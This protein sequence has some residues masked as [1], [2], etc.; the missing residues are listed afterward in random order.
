MIRSPTFY[1]AYMAGKKYLK[2]DT[3]TGRPTQQASVD[4]SAG[5]GNAGDIVALDSSG[6]IDI[7]MM[8][9]GIGSSAATI[10]ASEALSAG[11]LVNVYDNSGTRTIRKANAT[12]ATKPAH[13]FVLLSVSSSANG[14]VY[15]DGQN[16]AIPIGTFVAADVGKM[17]FL[18]TIAGGVTITPPVS[19]GNIVQPLGAIISVGAAV[20]FDFQAN[21]YIV[22]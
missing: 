21:D 14:T 8:P 18:N 4:A 16:T 13:G 7:T 20:A 1:E 2:L 3:T 15:F 10:V 22:A 11:D 17:L 9:T 6:R 12:D 19:P 5:A